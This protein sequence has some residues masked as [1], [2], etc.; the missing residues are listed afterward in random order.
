WLVTGRVGN[1]PCRAGTGGATY[2]DAITMGPVGA[3]TPVAGSSVTAKL[4]A[5]SP[6]GSTLCTARPLA[7]TWKTPAGRGC[8]P[9]SA[10]SSYALPSGAGGRLATSRRPPA[11]SFQ[12]R[13]AIAFDADGLRSSTTR[14]AGS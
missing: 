9:P 5:D 8:G 4:L 12:I 14:V 11:L 7:S 6:A 13:R 1:R 2:L 10:H 3:G